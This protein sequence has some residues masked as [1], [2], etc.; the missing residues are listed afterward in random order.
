MKAF[1][2]QIPLSLMSGLVV[3][4]LSTAFSI[5]FASLIFLWLRS[6]ELAL[7]RVQERG[8]MGGHAVP[9]CT[10]RRRYHVGLRNFFNLYISQLLM[11]GNFTIT[12]MQNNS[13]WLPHKQKVTPFISSKLSYGNN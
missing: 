2:R 3:G 6:E 9:E 13:I 8:R 5:S 12:Q 10:I 7:S 11:H 1:F 4:L